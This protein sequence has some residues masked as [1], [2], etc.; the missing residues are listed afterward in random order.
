MYHLVN[1]EISGPI[2]KEQFYRLVEAIDKNTA[3]DKTKKY[4]LE[5][6]MTA[7]YSEIYKIDILDTII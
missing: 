3:Y 6:Y 5:V 7:G 1:V 2:N 4:L